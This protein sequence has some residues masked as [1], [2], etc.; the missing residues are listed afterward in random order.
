MIPLGKLYEFV[1]AC[2]SLHVSDVGHYLVSTVKTRR[3]AIRGDW[4]GLGCD[5]MTSTV[6][7]LFAMMIDG[8]AVSSLI[9]SSLFRNRIK[10]H[11]QD[12][13]SQQ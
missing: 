3:P 2:R 1:I 9:V 11:K 10:R 6:A 8:V 13:S 7:I 12:S 4:N 5:F